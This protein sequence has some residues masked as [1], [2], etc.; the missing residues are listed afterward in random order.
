MFKLIS[1][2]RIIIP[3]LTVRPFSTSF[4][5]FQESKVLY[6]KENVHDLETFLTQIGRNTIEFKDN[7][8]NDLNKF[9]AT[10]SEQMKEMGI[11]TNQRK[12]L[13][14]WKDKFINNTEP[15]KE[16]K[17]G[18]KRNGGERKAKTVKA[19]RLALQR[20]EERERFAKEAENNQQERIF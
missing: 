6:T 20:I 11:D 15:L 17:T 3:T 14:R 7:F 2:S 16:H 18:K 19:R 9:L 12:Y 13:L 5:N 4:R 8:D 1:R 10:T